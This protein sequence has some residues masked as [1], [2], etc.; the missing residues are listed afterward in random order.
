MFTV[1]LVVVVVVVV[2][3]LAKASC[4]GLNFPA[5]I[6]CRR[7]KQRERE[8]GESERRKW[9][10]WKWRRVIE[11]TICVLFTQHTTLFCFLG[12]ESV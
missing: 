8:S 11:R 4:H 12:A 7:Q 1:A 10:I 3:G 5:K 9:R 2:G 6:T